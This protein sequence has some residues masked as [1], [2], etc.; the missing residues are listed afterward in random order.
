MNCFFPR[1][2]RLPLAAVLGMSLLTSSALA[3]I[4]LVTLPARERVEVQLENQ[5]A[6]LIE[7]E[8]IVPLIKGSNQIDFSWANTQINPDTIVL[9]VL[10]PGDGKALEANVIA[11]NYP[12]AEQALVWDVSASRSGSARVRI[13]YIL[14]GLN[15]SF[16]YRAVANQTESELELRQ[17]IR[18]HNFAQE[19]YG[20]VTLNIG[21]GQTL[22][23]PMGRNETRELLVAQTAG[24][25]IE[26]TYTC[27]V[28]EYG[29]SDQPKNRLAVPMHYVINN[30]ADHKLGL[31]PLPYGKVRIFQEDSRGTRAFIGE[32]WGQATPRKKAMKLAL[33]QAQDVI[34]ER[35]IIDRKRTTLG[36]NMYRQEV[37]IQ[38]EIQNTKDK[39]IKLQVKEAI[40]HLQ[41]ELGI[42]QNKQPSWT[43]GNKTTLPTLLKDETD[44]YTVSHEASLPARDGDET[45]KKMYRLHLVF[46]SVF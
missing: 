7:E 28:S 4:R 10:G 38:Y 24:I 1:S 36:A 19:N 42:P 20:D 33:G 40:G 9:R 23:R 44:L 31:A 37:T 22:D 5:Q 27:N 3:R 15:R 35:K 12:P 21:H 46:D 6:T 34:V 14:G 13:S 25:P 8:R 39:P 43:I 29:Y 2:W 26:K 32:D 17:Y 30:D 45:E 41:N 11:V 16:A 18:V